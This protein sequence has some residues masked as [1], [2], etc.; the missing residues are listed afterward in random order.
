MAWRVEMTDESEAQMIL[1]I[2][3]K[4][5]SKDDIAVLKK[6]IA[7]VEENGIEAAQVS[8][9]WRDHELSGKW[10]GHRAISFSVSG[11]V[12]YGIDKGKVIVR[13]VKVTVDHDYS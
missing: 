8:P 5:I 9:S 2:R 3:A 4:K 10:K 6:W 12:I 11:R 7:D 1:D 13:V